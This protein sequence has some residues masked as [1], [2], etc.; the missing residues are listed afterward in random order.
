MFNVFLN[1]M[2]SV[3]INHEF[4]SKCVSNKWGNYFKCH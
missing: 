1:L 2:V 4:D 3:F